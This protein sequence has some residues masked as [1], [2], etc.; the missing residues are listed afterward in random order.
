MVSLLGPPPKK[1]LEQSDKCRRYWDA[2]GKNCFLLHGRWLLLISTGNWIAATPIPD[3]TLES[4]KTRLEGND[5]KLLVALA[6]KMLRWLPEERPC[7]ETIIEEDEFL[8]QIHE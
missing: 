7:A 4:R 5:K 1:F 6:R 8:N 3:Q 2:Q